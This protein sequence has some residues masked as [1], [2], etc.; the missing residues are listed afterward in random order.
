MMLPELENNILSV[1]V[2]VNHSTNS[3][4]SSRS[5]MMMPI[6]TWQGCLVPRRTE[7]A[8]PQTKERERTKRTSPEDASDG[9]ARWLAIKCRATERFFLFFFSWKFMPHRL[10]PVDWLVRLAWL[11]HTCPVLACLWPPGLFSA[12]A[13]TMPTGLGSTGAAVCKLRQ[14]SHPTKQI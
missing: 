2:C 12:A 8:S 1:C 3:S 6:D 10:L 5:S 9:Q 4:S 13:N 7:N 14:P 11:L